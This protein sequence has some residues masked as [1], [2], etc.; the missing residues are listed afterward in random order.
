MVPLWVEEH[1]VCLQYEALLV[2]KISKPFWLPFVNVE[3][4]FI[5]TQ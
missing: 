5:S 3:Y 1:T 4:E 2:C